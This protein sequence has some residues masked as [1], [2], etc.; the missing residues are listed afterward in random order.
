[1]GS[2]NI[3]AKGGGGVYVH[4]A[5]GLKVNDRG[6][7]SPFRN[8]RAVHCSRLGKGYLNSETHLQDRKILL[9]LC[10]HYRLVVF[11]FVIGRTKYTDINGY[12]DYTGTLDLITC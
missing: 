11:R 6:L 7:H 8:G 5:N 12:R 9:L 3:N 1:M 10:E 2:V 4:N